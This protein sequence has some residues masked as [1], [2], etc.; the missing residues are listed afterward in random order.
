MLPEM[1]PLCPGLILAL[2]VRL[3]EATV[4][5]SVDAS[6][7]FVCSYSGSCNC[8]LHGSCHSGEIGRNR[9]HTK[10]IP[11]VF[12]ALRQEH[13]LVSLSFFFVLTVLSVGVNCV[14]VVGLFI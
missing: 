14:S 7:A 3:G 10:L 1:S 8:N 4:C 11:A 2:F 13:H 12:S 6:H 9:N 5:P